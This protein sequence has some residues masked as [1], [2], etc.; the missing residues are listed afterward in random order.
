M[1]ELAE[2]KK[3]R[4]NAAAMRLHGRGL[5]YATIGERHV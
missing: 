2:Q 5:Y 4:S 3:K 1:L